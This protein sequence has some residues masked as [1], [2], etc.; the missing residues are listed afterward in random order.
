MNMLV[1]WLIIMVVSWALAAW[2]LWKTDLVVPREDKVN[3][4]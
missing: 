3:D 1:W 2:V 4:E